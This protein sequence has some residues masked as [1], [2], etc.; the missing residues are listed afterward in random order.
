M[1][2][3]PLP[4]DQL[5]IGDN[6]RR[7][8]DQRLQRAVREGELTLGE[9]EER[10]TLL[11]AARTRGEL[12]PLTMDLV[13]VPSAPRRGAVR[14]E[15]R[16]RDRGA[17]AARARRWFVG[18]LGGDV[19]KGPV[20]QGETTVA[21]AVMGGVEIDLRQ[22]DLPDEVVVTATAVMGGVEVIVPVGVEVDLRG[23][24]VMGGREVDVEPAVPGAPVVRVN[25]YALMGGVEVGHGPAH[26]RVALGERNAA[27]SLPAATGSTAVGGRRTGP[28]LGGAVMAL[29]L[30]GALG[31]GV[32]ATDA[33]AVMGGRTVSVP[34]SLEPGSVVDL[35]VAVLMG[36][37][38][39]VVPDGYRVEQGGLVVMGGTDCEACADV[40]DAD[41]PL[42]RVDG[43]GAMGGVN[44]VRP[45]QAEADEDD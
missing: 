30:V 11:Y 27:S 37:V 3:Q 4:P 38:E 7:A 43:Y 45:D 21:V 42:V 13:E 22:P 9:Y 2:V 35:D 10:A 19:R 44:I 41:A 31:L 12:V 28:G 24:A 33:M 1:D 36:G 29:G 25:G 17:R 34:A 40:V 32:A 15:P 18:I 6:D 5:R 8:V 14:G 23:F 39:V 26:Q 20:P 16:R